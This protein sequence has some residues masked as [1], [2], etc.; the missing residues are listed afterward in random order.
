MMSRDDEPL[1]SGHEQRRQ[2]IAI[3]MRVRGPKHPAPTPLINLRRAPYIPIARSN[4]LP[5]PSREYFW[6][7]ASISRG[8]PTSQC[9]GSINGC[10]R[11]GIDAPA[12]SFRRH[13]NQWQASMNTRQQQVV[14]SVSVGLL[15]ASVALFPGC[16]GGGGGGS[17]NTSNPSMIS[18]AG[19]AATGKALAGATISID[20]ARGSMSVAADANGSYHATFGAAMPCM[21]AATSG[22]TMLQRS[23]AARTMSR[24]R[25][26]YCCRIWRH[27]SGRMKAGSSPASPRTCSFSRRCRIRPTF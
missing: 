26:I 21:I 16:G 27:N 4:G 23:L 10:A 11:D 3:A 5:C 20:C 6:R 8:Q 13:T 1:C 12:E 18:I 7:H 15:S 14:R 22:G 2:A 9:L 17:G 25:P 19:T 24:R